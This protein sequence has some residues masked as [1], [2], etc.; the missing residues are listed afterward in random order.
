[1]IKHVMLFKNF[2]HANASFGGKVLYNLLYNTITIQ[3]GGQASEK[4]WDHFRQDSGIIFKHKKRRKGPCSSTQNGSFS[5]IP[6][7]FY[8]ST[9]RE[10]YGY[11]GIL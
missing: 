10:G 4:Y 11:D 3:L 5:H 9:I 7:R 1:M 6:L 2:D 8:G